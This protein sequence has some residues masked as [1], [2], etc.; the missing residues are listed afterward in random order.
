MD[1]SHQGG[2]SA[3]ALV[4]RGLADESW[5]WSL[6]RTGAIAEFAR[7]PGDGAVVRPGARGGEVAGRLGAIRI[8]LDAEVVP[9]AY[10]AL[11]RDRG[12]WRHGLAFCL[13]VRDRAPPAGV[14]AEAGPDRGAL[15]TCDRDALLFDL[16]IGSA[17]VVAYVRTRDEDLIAALRQGA[18]RSLLEPGNPAMAA[19]LAHS[20][21]RVFTARIA[22]IEVTQAI[23]TDRS[24]VG[25]HTHVLPRLLAAGREHA[26]D[27]PVPTGMAAPLVAYPPNP[28]TD[29]EG[30]PRPF[31]RAAHDAFQALLCAHG[32]PE[33]LAAKRCTEAALSRGAPPPAGWRPRTRIARTAVRV[34]LRQWRHLH[35][36]GPLIDCWQRACEPARRNR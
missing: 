23:A 25:P 31:D 13:P 26:A 28:V 8:D 32:A 35:G 4:R 3:A 18:G 16:G 33:A 34:A 17:A 10:E 19:I 2:I 7:V 30:R 5:S 22:R 15:R 24:P 12:R 29:A 6:G 20:P 1:H 9:L 14:L 21:H 27:I 11:S 36:P